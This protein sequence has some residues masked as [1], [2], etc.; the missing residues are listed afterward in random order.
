MQ[1]SGFK[2][3]SRE[4]ETGALGEDDSLAPFGLKVTFVSEEVNDGGVIGIYTYCNVV[5]EGLF[6]PIRVSR[7]FHFGLCSHSIRVYSVS[8]EVFLKKFLRRNG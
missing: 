1:L 5:E 4:E 7:V 3:K 6:G 8:A 2:N